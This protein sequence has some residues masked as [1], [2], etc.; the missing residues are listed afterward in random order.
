M[1]TIPKSDF[2]NMNIMAGTAKDLLQEQANSEDLQI[3]NRDFDLFAN[4]LAKFADP[5]IG[6]DLGNEKDFYTAALQVAKGY[7]DAKSFG[8][9]KPA[10][11]QFGFRLLGP[12]DLKQ[13]SSALTPAY[14]SWLQTLTTSSGHTY[15]Q[16]AYGYSSGNV[17]SSA[18][19]TQKSVLA[20]HKLISYNPSP[21]LQY[22]EWNI[23]G[24]PYVPYSVEPFSNIQKADGK[25]FKL[26]PLPG[27]IIINPGGGFYTHFYFDLEEGYSSLS[28][29]TKDVDV[30]VALF[31]LVFAEYDYLKAGTA[32]LY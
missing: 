27:R 31:G 12:Q 19:S 6:A 21:R 14:I 9:L 26:I 23:N 4:E 5:D 16:Y 18:V 32:V 13:A 15:K 30:N 11:G 22:V 25:L 3:W 29:T 28:G 1:A 20:W 17:Y 8:G 7:F 24:G 2:T 10:T